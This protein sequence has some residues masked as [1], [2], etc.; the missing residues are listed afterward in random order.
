MG[1]DGS[2]G[3]PQCRCGHRSQSAAGISKLQRAAK[4]VEDAPGLF[5]GVEIT[6]SDG[7]HLLLLMDP[8]CTQQHI[9]DLLSSVE[10]PVDKR[11][12][13]TARSP[14]GIE[15]ILDACEDNALIVGAH[16]NAP[17]GLLQYGGQQ[18]LAVL[19]HRNLRS[20]LIRT[21]ALTKAGLMEA[22]AR[23]GVESRRCTPPTVTTL[24]SWAGAS[25]G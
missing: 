18:R 15:Q 6:A 22:R 3:G 9:D 11:G 8:D 21:G 4:G 1:E 24:T 16:V 14:L 7:I 13:E 20:R 25:P 19:R 2:H 23:S 17:D 10:I 12:G 5:P